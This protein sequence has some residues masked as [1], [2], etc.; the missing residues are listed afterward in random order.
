MLDQV[1]RGDPR[2]RWLATL[3][4]CG[5]AILLV[6]LWYVQVVSRN[7]YENS[8]KVQSFR[9]VRVPAAR[10]RILDRNGKVLADNQPRYNINLFL[11]DIRGQF[12][13]EYTNSLVKE[14]AAKNGR[15]PKTLAEKAELSERARYRVVSNIVWQ[16][17]TAV[18]PQPLVLNPFAFEKHY[19][20]KRAIPMPLVTDL[21]PQQIALFMERASDLPGIELEVEPYRFYPFG[22]L[23]S[24][25]L[26]YVLREQKSD[27]PGSENEMNFHYRLPDYQ[28]AIG[29]EG[30]FDTELRGTAGAKAILVNNI[31]YRQSEETWVEPA[32]GKNVMVTLDL[33]LQ[34]AAERSLLM[35]GPDTRGSVVVVNCKT[36]DILAMASAPSYDLNMFVR[37]REFGTND[38]NR[39]Q[40]EVLTPQYNR[41]LQ[42]AY[43]PGSIFK[44]VVGLACLENGIMSP[45][46]TVTVPSSQLYWV[47][48]RSIRDTAPPGVYDF[49]EAF[50]H[51]CNCYF[52]EFG[53]KAGLDRIV[54]MGNRFNLGEKTGVVQPSLEQKGLFPELGERVKKSGDKWTEGDTANLCIGQGEITV[55]PL[56]MALMTAAVANGG[57][58]LKPRLVVELEDQRGNRTA[59]SVPPAQVERELKVS[60]HS[61]ELMHQAMLADVEEPGGSGKAAFIPGMGISGKT[62]TAQFKKNGRMD[63]ITWFVSFAP[64]QDPKYAVVVM[65]ESGASGGGTCAPKAKEIYK[66]IQKLENER[67]NQMAAQ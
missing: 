49:K 32:P 10:G 50:K 51:S 28:G 65:V 3:F 17:S 57:K 23:A 1:K 16:V 41:A 62:G 55:T 2:L 52:I 19:A 59:E 45:D 43:Q 6:G 11:E 15:R 33:E 8:L 63:H 34:K 35:S 40:D 58:L 64:F 4:F 5:F 27:E 30:G 47:G 53:L 60:A 21:T 25:V 61:L 14:F 20:E 29:L 12:T 42:G 26:G 7:K 22:S 54:E 31:G 9:T 18:L 13:F 39:L 66:T 44:I 67:L 38:W 36:G 56:Q 46:E 48:R 24:H 37:P